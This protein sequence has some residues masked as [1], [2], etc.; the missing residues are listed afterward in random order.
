MKIARRDGTAKE[1]SKIIF[2]RTTDRQ[3]QDL[4]VAEDQVPKQCGC[5]KQVKLR[6]VGRLKYRTK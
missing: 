1:V 3:E 5:E 2:K 6:S 4:N